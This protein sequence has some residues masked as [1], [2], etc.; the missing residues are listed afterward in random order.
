MLQSM[1]RAPWRKGG[2]VSAGLGAVALA[3]LL[4][5]L[6][7]GCGGSSPAPE[8]SGTPTGSTPRILAPEAVRLA[9][10][11]MKSAGLAVGPGDWRLYSIDN[12]F[13]GRGSSVTGSEILQSFGGRSQDE[14]LVL[15]AYVVGEGAR[16]WFIE[17]C[18][19][20]EASQRAA[21]SDGEKRLQSMR[22]VV[23]GREASEP[24]GQTYPLATGKKYLPEGPLNASWV[25][26]VDKAVR[27]AGASPGFDRAAGF[28]LYNLKLAKGRQQVWDI[29][30]ADAKGR[31]YG[32]PMKEWKRG[33]S[34]GYGFYSTDEI[35]E[36][37]HG[38][39]M[40]IVR[41]SADGSRVVERDY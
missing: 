5:L 2:S 18:K 37:G 40:A 19:L 39:I 12:Y 30:C 21:S 1:R 9:T 29:A 7:M 17:F 16:A 20:G 4:G 3:L 38:Q 10:E 27:L 35:S 6:L 33:S 41:V 25:D 13:G 31:M 36:S 22:V 15:T 8:E 11:S 32:V 23:I 14:T 34:E 24:K 28:F 26:A